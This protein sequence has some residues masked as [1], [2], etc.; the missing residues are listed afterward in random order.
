MNEIDDLRVEALFCSH[1]QPSDHPS[2]ALVR[3]T[4]YA[5]V[6][7][8]REDGCAACVAQECGDHPE[9]AVERMRWARAA[10]AE[11]FEFEPAGS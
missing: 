6:F 7:R 4:V 1:L 2:P 5:E 8:R 10:V 3:D 9:A 11:A